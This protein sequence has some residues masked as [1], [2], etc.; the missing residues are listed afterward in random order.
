MAGITLTIA[1]AQLT[2]WLA[3]LDAIATGQTYSIGGRSLTR[4]N[5]ADAKDQ[6]E[7]WDRKVKR[8]SKTAGGI[9]VKGAELV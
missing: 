8:L 3:C 4:A 1:E 7:Y 5:L 9:P 2:Q 6:V